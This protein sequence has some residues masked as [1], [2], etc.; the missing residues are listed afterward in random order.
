MTKDESE[1]MSAYTVV[2]DGLAHLGPGDPETTRNIAERFSPHLP[3][4][5]RVADFGC[6]VGA[7]TIVLAQSLPKARILA[8][9]SHA[10]FI[11]RLQTAAIT[12]GFN[13]RI[14]AMV[15]D[16]AEPPPLDHISVNLQDIV[17]AWTIN[18]GKN[19]PKIEG[20]EVKKTIKSGLI[21]EAFLV[22]TARFKNNA[23]NN[24]RL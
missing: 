24:N 15:G 1:M 2:F 22:F 10:P 8:L 23:L 20:V 17:A 16:M 14:T 9:D 5:P 18:P 13:E 7:S 11:S 6:G 19:T 3:S 12:Q 21:F 4:E